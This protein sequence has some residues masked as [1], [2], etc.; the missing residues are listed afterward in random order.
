MAHFIFE[1]EASASYITD[2]PVLEVLVDGSVVSSAS[3]TGVTGFGTSSLYFE[4]EYSGTAP[5]S[6]QFRFNDASGEGGRQV[7][8][9]NV[10]I[11][12]W[13]VDTTYIS[14]MT[15]SQGNSANINIA[16][17]DH[18]YGRQAPVTGDVG[19]VTDSGSSSGD[20]IKVD[21]GGAGVVEA[22][23]GDDR[24]RGADD[25]DALFGDGGADVLYGGAGNDIIVGGLGNDNLYGEAGDDLLHGGN[26]IDILNGG[27]G[28]DLL[29][30][31]AGA[32]MLMG[33]DGN[34]ISY[35]EAGNDTISAGAGNDIAYGDGGDDILS[36]GIGNDTLYGGADA[37]KLY[38]EAG[39][40]LL[41]GEDGNDQIYGGL[42]SDTVDGGAGDD[43]LQ[44]GAGADILNG[45]N[46]NDTINGGA[47][48]DTIDG[49]A[50]TDVAILTG[51]WASYAI[52]L[53]GSTYTLVH[54]T[55]GTD[56][57][58]A[59][60]NFQFSNG[61]VAVASLLNVAPTGANA[62][63]TGAE[64]TDLVLAA[65]NFGFSDANALDALSAVR[66]DSL[67]AA[68]TL[69][70][71]GVAVTAGQVVSVSD[72]NVGNLTFQPASGA[73]G[74]PYAN[75]TFSVR[76]LGGLYDAA[77]N[78]ITINVTAVNDTPTI[79]SNGGG[80]S[81][82][83]SIGEN[84]TAVTIVTA[85]DPDIPTT[86]TYSIAGGA[87][88][89]RFAID[90][91][92]GVLT[93][94][95]A[96]NYESPTDNGADNI[97]DVIVQVSDGS[98]TDTQTLAVTVTNVNETPTITSNGGGATASVTINENGAI[99][100]TVAATDPDASTTLT[101][102][103]SGGA[104]SS[105]FVIDS[106][107]GVL[108]F[109]LAPDY[110]VP[111]DS[112][113]DNVYDVT[114][115]ASDGSLS[116]SQNISVVISDV[117]EGDVGNTTGTAGTVAVGGVVA[118]TVDTAGDRDWFQVNLTAGTKYAIWARGTPTEAGTMT[119]PRIHSI[120]NSAGTSVN[121]GDDDGG[122]GYDSL[123]YYTPT[124]TGTYYIEMGAYGATQTGT[125]TLNVFVGGN[126]YTGSSGGNTLTGTANADY[127]DGQGGA[128]TLN[129]G[130][131]SDILDGG[132]GNDILV[133]GNGADVLLGGSNADTFRFT[134][135]DAVDQIVDYTTAQSDVL[136]IANILTGFTAGV[137]DIDDFVQFQTVDGDTVMRVDAD[138]TANGANF[139]QVATLLGTT[140]LTVQTLYD[141]S[142]IDAT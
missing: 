78:T 51:T 99:V 42:G 39:D 40:D 7:T 55:D 43:L 20:Y 101:Y 12:G 92:T 98:L 18:L 83:I 76:D 115:T 111:A 5:T 120:R 66:I 36:G 3:V 37:D 107:T 91:A 38:G 16:G 94:L 118:G 123:L 6:L 28:N 75:F 22:G 13:S 54:A 30:G 124:T 35:G 137:S 23:D 17:T 136:D 31:G 127:L 109:I 45:G 11:S 64:D 50:G 60:E 106:V 113:N 58:T 138:G 108:A 90:S 134:A 68:G 65:G 114:V 77:P 10:K 67:P 26:D 89:A 72:I 126:T 130:D 105:L 117:S 48:N 62:T 70:L 33:G 14:V 125:Y 93:F 52:S 142:L 57:V 121:S 132:S 69:R 84:G 21:S 53:A 61:T 46:D 97:Y 74:S 110:E 122:V 56:N 141:S 95:T 59:V 80:S 103:I 41:Y 82:S 119:D 100:T 25:D 133:G 44:G 49:G 102:S 131:G 71:S 135:T 112:G 4:L 139:V 27:A 24:V 34:D 116:D 96:P 9:N 15:L 129:G 2:A 87:D 29:N 1:I 32:D 86:L 73:S 104:D 88:A 79:T 63:L 140:G 8:I 47:G 19:A 81:A 128:D 85:T